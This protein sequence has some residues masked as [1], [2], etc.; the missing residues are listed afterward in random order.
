MYSNN[1]RKNSKPKR[2]TSTYKMANKRRKNKK[3]NI[4]RE[5]RN[6]YNRDTKGDRR[7]QEK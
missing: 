4:D 5:T 3:Q 2:T 6:T 1:K 7:I